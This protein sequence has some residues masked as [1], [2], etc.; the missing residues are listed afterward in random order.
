MVVGYNI[1]NL[2]VFPYTVKERLEAEKKFKITYTNYIKNMNY[3]MIKWKKKMYKR[4]T[5]KTTN[6][7]WENFKKT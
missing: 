4:C 2:I 6:Y 7:S 5:L 3:L 1:Q